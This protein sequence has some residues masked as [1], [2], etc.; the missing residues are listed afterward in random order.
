MMVLE[1]ELPHVYGGVGVPHLLMQ[2][3]EIQM[4]KLIGGALST[5]GGV[6]PVAQRAAAYHLSSGGQRIRAQLA[7]QASLALK[8][9]AGDAVSLAT[10]VELT[11][12]A[13]L[14]HDDLQDRDATRR[15]TDTVWVAFGDGV[16][17]C[18]GDALLSAAY[19]ALAAISR[20]HLLPTLIPLLHQ[21][22][23][24]AACGQCVDLTNT[25]SQRMSF[26]HYIQ[27]AAL[28]SGALLALPIEL[29]L[30]AAGQLQAIPP[31][32][33]AAELFAVAYQI[34]DDL[35]DV[36]TDQMRCTAQPAV[37]AVTVLQ[38]CHPGEDAR[39]LARQHAL[40]YL[41]EAVTASGSLPDQSGHLLGRLAHELSAQIVSGSA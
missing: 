9:P 11:H 16:A 26:D 4:H 36:Q 15:G 35:N 21:R 6:D 39:A 2:S 12:N 8:L 30:A 1:A 17:I 32:R 5:P 13:S 24:D 40:G 18:A 28:K 38:A 27:I 41:K 20:P 29:S 7:I 19:C 10:T 37:N 14:V 33:R 23:A 3:V 25:P 31:A 22:I 34:F